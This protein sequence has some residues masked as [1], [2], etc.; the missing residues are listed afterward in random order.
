MYPLCNG[1]LLKSLNRDSVV[2][3]LKVHFGR[4]ENERDQRW[5][6]EKGLRD[7]CNNA[8]EEMLMT[9]TRLGDVNGERHMHIC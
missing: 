5:R 9:W 2:L 6:W 1:K 8:S 7:Y 3:F 4:H